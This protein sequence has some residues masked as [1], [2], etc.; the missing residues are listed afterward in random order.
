MCVAQ[1][2]SDRESQF[3]RLSTLAQVIRKNSY[4]PAS[5]PPDQC[6]NT[7]STDSSCLLPHV[8]A[9]PEVSSSPTPAV[10]THSALAR[11]GISLMKRYASHPRIKALIAVQR[12][13]QQDQVFKLSAMLAYRLI[14]TVV[15]VF[16][17]LLSVEGFVLRIMNPEARHHLIYALADHVPG[18]SGF[19]PLALAQLTEQAAA[20]AVLSVVTSVYFG[21]RLFTAID[22]CFDIIFKVPPRHLMREQ[23]MAFEMLLFFI[24]LVP[25]LFIIS[26]IP[27]FL[28][29]PGTAQSLFGGAWLTPLCVII[30]SILA[31][32]LIASVLFLLCY[33]VIPNRTVPVR[34]VWKG[35]LI[36]GALLEIVQQSFPVYA[37]RYLNGGNATVSVGIGLVAIVFFYYFGLVLLLGAEINAYF[38]DRDQQSLTRY[39]DQVH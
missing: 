31:G 27:G 21:S 26:L 15:P 34:L 10:S 1:S 3:Q 35:A 39:T 32:W 20:L 24:L 33:V 13:L 4:M 11:G 2:G 8:L 36:A 28:S 14:I 17:L 6:A 9:D 29:E 18:A 37:A 16:V 12:R 7:E 23:L 19:L 38:F 30:V 25:V 22:Y 5:H